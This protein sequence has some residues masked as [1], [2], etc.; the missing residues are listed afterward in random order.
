MRREPLRA[1]HAVEPLPLLHP[2]EPPDREAEPHAVGETERGEPEE[3][4]RR[5][6]RVHGPP[7]EEPDRR[8]PPEKP[9]GEPQLVDQAQDRGIGLEY[10]VDRKSVV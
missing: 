7:A 8:R 5:G 10:M 9:F 6:E 3:V 1:R 2:L 4:P